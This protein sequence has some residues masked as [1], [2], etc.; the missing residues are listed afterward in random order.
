MALLGYD[1][2][3]FVKDTIDCAEEPMFEKWFCKWKAHSQYCY[4][5]ALVIHGCQ[6]AWYWSVLILQNN[7]N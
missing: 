3:Y 6:Y 5:D 1:D 7:E 2:R 4:A